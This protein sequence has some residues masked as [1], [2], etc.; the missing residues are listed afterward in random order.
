MYAL[1]CSIHKGFSNRRGD[2]NISLMLSVLV[3]GGFVLFC[4]LSF[5]LL[6]MH[7]QH[8]EVPRLGVIR[9]S[10]GNVRSEP[11]LQRTPQ[12]MAMLDL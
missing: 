5:V 8:M 7:Q 6:G 3:L 1:L 2:K 11:C 9:Q 10:H 12:L 4:S